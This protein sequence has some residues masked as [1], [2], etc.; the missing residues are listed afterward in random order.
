MAQ[1]CGLKLQ[2]RIASAYRSKISCSVRAHART[3]VAAPRLTVRN[4]D[5]LIHN[6]DSEGTFF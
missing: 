6:V 4:F 2:H 3:C 5:I 1:G